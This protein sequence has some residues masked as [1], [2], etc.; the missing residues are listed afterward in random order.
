MR[1]KEFCRVRDLPLR[2]YSEAEKEEL[3][4]Q[5]TAILR[6]PTGTMKLRPIQAVAL[7]EI[8]MYHGLLGPILV[9]GGKTLVSLLAAFMV[10]A[11]R[12]L[13]ILPARLEKKTQRE[14]AELA[15]HW[16]IPFYIHTI[17]YEKL[18]RESAADFLEKWKFDC[19]VAD[20][21]HKLKNPKAAATRRLK[22]YIV[23]Q[24]AKGAQVVFVSLS[25]TM[26]QRS[27]KEYA[28]LSDWA[29][30]Q[31]SPLPLVQAEVDKWSAALDESSNVRMAPGALADFA[32]GSEDLAAVRR[33]F[34]DRLVGT[35]GVVASN[36]DALGCSLYINRIEFPY[37]PELETHFY[38]LRRRDKGGGV[39]PDGYPLVSGLEF[40][41][42]ARCLS[43]G[44]FQ[45]WNPRAPDWWLN[46]RRDWGQFVRATL[47]RSRTLDTELQVANACAR[48]ELDP[49]AWNAWVAVRDKFK[50]NPE[51][52]WLTHDIAKACA[53]WLRESGHHSIVWT[54]VPDF[55]RLVAHFAGVPY[56][57]QMG[58]TAD[59][60][61][62]DR[63]P[64]D[65]L[66]ASTPSNF[67]GRNLQFHYNKNLVVNPRKRGGNW[68]QLLGREHRPG[69]FSDDVSWDVLSMCAED[70]EAFAQAQVDAQAISDREGQIQKL[71]YADITWELGSSDYDSPRWM[72][73][74][75]EWR[76]ESREA[77]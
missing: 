62:I 58:L 21:T 53:Q 68:E 60:R 15:K 25:G 51:T 4:Q 70:E 16:K 37:P 5:L 66:V 50:P 72:K 43:V 36:E 71:S 48:G 64:G 17:S 63:I 14:A 57:G 31:G 32:G 59:G 61:E 56:V 67:E 20:E 18:S 46:P 38:N 30:D 41:H 52:V 34:R 9:G 11:K 6:T 35:G 28:H 23:G 44:C 1:T 12:P 47:S 26:A 54:E 75:E 39:T 73:D 45:R 3:A 69:H 22:R 77:D 40:F 10:G 29:L 8:G 65:P 74:P 19:I 24:R 55:G 7:C 33:G 49:Q 76:W 27:I 2:A 13:L 42:A